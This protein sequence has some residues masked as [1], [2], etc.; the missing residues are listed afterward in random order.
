MV[1]VTSGLAGW[2]N[3]KEENRGEQE[4]GEKHRCRRRSRT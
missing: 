1:E 4:Q 2:T 3:R